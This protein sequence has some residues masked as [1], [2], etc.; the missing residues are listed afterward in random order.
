MLRLHNI[1][2]GIIC[3]SEQT[4]IRL[5]FDITFG[6]VPLREFQHFTE[7]GNEFP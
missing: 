5:K 1:G 4:H 3:L 2:I 7:H 6:N